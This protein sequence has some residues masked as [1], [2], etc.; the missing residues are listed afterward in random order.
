MWLPFYIQERIY[1]RQVSFH[2]QEQ[3]LVTH[4]AVIP[5]AGFITYFA[6]FVGA[7]G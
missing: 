2:L 6:V 3:L 4:I 7:L 5:L 1:V